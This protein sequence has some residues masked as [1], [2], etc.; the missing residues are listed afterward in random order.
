MKIVHKTEY[1]WVCE[2]TNQP[3]YH[4]KEVTT[5]SCMPTGWFRMVSRYGNTI[6]CSLNCM[7]GYL[8]QFGGWRKVMK[9]EIAK[10]E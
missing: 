1:H 10:Y 6:H 7:F 4:K 3:C 5:N 8:A 2:S 9:Q